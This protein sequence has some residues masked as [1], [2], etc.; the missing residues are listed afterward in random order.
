MGTYCE[1]VGEMKIPEDKKD[2]FVK[3]IEKLLNLGGVMQVE[4]V[5][6]YGFSQNLL[7]PLEISSGETV[8][9][10][11]NYFEDD[12]W[13]TAAFDPENCMLYTNKVGSQEFCDVMVAAYMLYE[14]YTRMP[15]LVTVNGEIE[16]YIEIVGWLNQALGTDFSMKKRFELWKNAELL[17]EQRLEDYD[18]PFS[19][20]DLM[21]IIPNGMEYAAGGTELADLLYISQGTETLTAEEV[22][23]GSYPEDIFKFKKLIMKYL[24]EAGAEEGTSQLLNLI[25]M[26]RD[27]RACVKDEGLA[28]VAEMSLVLP[29]RVIVYLTAE[30][31]KMKFWKIWP[32]LSKDVYHDEQGKQYASEELT[33]ERKRI[34]EMPIPKIGTSKYLR[35]DGGIIFWKTPDE[36]KGKPNYYLSDDDRLYWW[37]EDSDEVCISEATDKWLR[38]LAER[39][40]EIVE[41]LD[42][43]L[44]SDHFL[45][46]FLALLKEITTIYKRVYPFE[47]MFYEFLRNHNQKEYL[48]AIELLRQLKDENKEEGSVIEKVLDRP[49]SLSSKNVLFNAARL[50][51][52]RYLSLLANCELRK[53]YLGF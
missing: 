37:K 50:R 42:D 18:D 45:R 35:Q 32:E 52:K 10:H 3:Q 2:L 44:V 39:H 29:A 46:D 38:R 28:E 25:K 15:G 13:E 48:A 47:T 12:A 7:I 49:W 33:A 14:I 11:F 43:G 30:H 23:P 40:R 36:L 53:K 1:Y 22:V 8:R 51:M 34:R 27:E 6:I 17:A 31:R 21:R 20:D 19:F 26:N 24:D 5:N 16:S 4:S 41:N 9:F